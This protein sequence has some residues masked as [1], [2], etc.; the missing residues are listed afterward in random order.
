MQ[1][2]PTMDSLYKPKGFLPNEMLQVVF[3]D[4]WNQSFPV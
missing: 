1:L 2:Y 4:I 3:K